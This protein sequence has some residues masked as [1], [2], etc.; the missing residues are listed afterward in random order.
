MAMQHYPTAQFPQYP[1]PTPFATATAVVASSTA[2]SLPR[3]PLTA[4]ASG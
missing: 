4:P 2:P 1:M 3:Y